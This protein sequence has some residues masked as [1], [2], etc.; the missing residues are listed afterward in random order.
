MMCTSGLRGY[1][2]VPTRKP[3]KTKSG[4]ERRH[5]PPQGGGHNLSDEQLDRVQQFRAKVRGTDDPPTLR[6]PMAVDYEGVAQFTPRGL[7][8]AKGSPTEQDEGKH[9]LHFLP[10]EWMAPTTSPEPSRPAQG[11]PSVGDQTADAWGS[12]VAEG[13]MHALANRLTK[14]VAAS[15][16]TRQRMATQEGDDG[17]QGTRAGAKRRSAQD[18]ERETK[19]TGPEAGPAASSSA[20]ASPADVTSA[21]GPPSEQTVAGSQRQSA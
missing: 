16:Q 9:I 7:G 8:E 15:Q 2:R 12:P 20:S 21:G 3:C 1:C 11:P 18:P 19:A 4:A 14:A 13:G 6:E 10:N 5:T 17:S